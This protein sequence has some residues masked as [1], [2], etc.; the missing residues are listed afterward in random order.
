M[1]VFEDTV[2]YRVWP[3][4]FAPG[5]VQTRLYAPPRVTAGA[6]APVTLIAVNRGLQSYAI[7]PT[8]QLRLTACWDDEC[9]ELA[10][11]MPLV[12]SPNGGASVIP[13]ALEAP[14]QPGSYQLTLREQSSFLG[15]WNGGA[16]VEVGDRTDMAF[17]VPAR[18][19][20][21]AVA[22]TAHPGRPLQVSLTWRPL[23]KI[24]AYYSVY[25]K[26]L[27]AAGSPVVSWDGQPQNGAAPTLLWVP[28]QRVQDTVTLEVPADVEPGVYS[29][30]V[31]MYRA[32][33]LARCLTLDEDGVPVDAI[34]VG[35][36]SIQP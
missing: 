29:V 19:T 17:P 24:D 20:A 2:V 8:D 34:D 22:P 7:L 13:L 26:L 15:G 11:D 23:G 28:D 30:Q 36:V 35:T 4:S 25:V 10:A 31:G 6:E 16:Q 18:L 27:D 1:E 33:D 3:R 9:T 5:E 21:W 32:E 14:S 12:T